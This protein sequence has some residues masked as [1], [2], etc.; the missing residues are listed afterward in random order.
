MKNS[1]IYLKICYNSVVFIV[2]VR[3]IQSNKKGLN[4]LLVFIN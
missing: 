1:K 2:R 3:K 4:Y